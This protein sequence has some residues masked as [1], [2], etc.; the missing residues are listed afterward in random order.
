MGFAL[1]DIAFAHPGKTIF[2]GLDLVLRKG[3]FTGIVG[4]NGCGK[5]TLLDLICRHRMPDRGDI[6]YGDRPLSEIGKRS[7]ARLIALVP[8]DYGI[9]FP[10]SVQEVVLMGRY[11]HT[12]RFG[13]PSG[14]D[15]D[16]VA[17][18]MADCG[19]L[20][21]KDRPV[22]TLSGGERQRVIFARALAQD[23]PVLVLDE[24]TANLDVHHT[25]ALLDRTTELVRDDRRTVV[26]VF[27]DLNLAAAYSQ[28]MVL[29]KAG[30]VVAAGPTETVLTPENLKKVF[31][32]QARVG[33]DDF[34]GRLQV[35]YKMP[36]AAGSP[37]SAPSPANG[38]PLNGNASYGPL[39]EN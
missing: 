13:A 23:T 21:L 19:I 4:P 14:E 24:A 28:E 10:F 29:M 11:P 22:T 5:T 8:Q 6:R 26:A 37:G 31:D 33:V 34:T 17:R 30:Q 25:L 20:A 3:R 32:I 38:A 36:E 2:D 27:Q 15:R 12:P 35:R 18:V 1:H 9:N 39:T 16:R 7:L